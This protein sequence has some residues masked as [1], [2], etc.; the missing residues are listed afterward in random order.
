MSF[1]AGI[2]L[3]AGLWATVVMTAILSASLGLGWT[4]LD[5][6]RLLGGM[7]DG[8]DRRGTMLGMHLHGLIGLAFGLAYG[9]LFAAMGVPDGTGEAMAIGACIGI[10]HWLLSMPLIGMAAALNAHVRAGR[11]MNPGLWGIH[12]GPQEGLMRLV[13]H[14]AFGM[15]MGGVSAW[16]QPDA[17]QATMGWLTVTGIL[18]W[19]GIVGYHVTCLAPSLLPRVTFEPAEDSA[20][21]ERERARQDLLARYRRGDLTWD[22][23]QHERRALASE[24]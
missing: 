5:F 18:G 21:E 6:G 4:H 20:S 16:L 8:I 12:L 1:D 24:P 2:A 22:E 13:A 7:L 10:Y 19:V 14:I 11:V 17:S 23:Y 15:T 3:C 9:W